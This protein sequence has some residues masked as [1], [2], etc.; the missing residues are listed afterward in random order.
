MQKLW[1]KNFEFHI[2]PAT[3]NNAQDMLQAGAVR[4]LREVEKH[5]WVALVADGEFS[6]EVET[7][8]SPHKIKAFTCECW[9]EGRRLMCAH[10][11]ATLYK[12]RQFLDQQAE[13]RLAKAEEKQLE[14]TG[15]L[16]TQTILEQASAPDLLEFVRMYARRDRDFALALKTWFAGS[17]SGAENPYILLI[18]SALPRR[19]GAHPL[20]EPEL[21]RLRKMLDDL[22]VQLGETAAQGNAQAVF[23]IATAILEKIMPLIPKT[24]ETK[25]DQLVHFCQKSLNHL[26]QLPVEQLS[27]ELRENRRHFLLGLVRKGALPAELERDVLHFLGQAATD[28]SLFQQIRDL[29]DHT[30]YPAPALILHLFLTALARRNMPEAVRRVLEDYTGHPAAIK[31][32]IVALH[33]LH[34]WPAVLTAG[35]YFTEK[36]LFNTSQRREIEDLMLLAAEKTADHP[37]QMKLLRA[38]YRE[39]GNPEMLQRLKTLAGAEWPAEQKRL[40][41]ELK[42]SGQTGRLAPL[43]AT[44]G[45]LGSLA[46]LIEEKNDLALLRQYEHLFFPAQASFVRDQYVTI[47]TAYLAEHFG[48]Q[49]SGFVREQLGGLLQKGQTEL[50]LGIIRTLSLRFPDRH[51]LP[52]ELAELFPKSKRLSILAK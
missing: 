17:L 33:Y 24:I 9:A 52:E 14:K 47:L 1:L 6:Y 11:A 41:A 38:R 32:A 5:F 40:V 2:N 4:N 31:D 19:A 23:R 22:E 29:F 10:I 12:I 16:S 46:R 7:I 36:K 50:V 21:K 48:R 49:A 26:L 35:E 25:R 42:E 34:A 43:F 27:P 44:D 30:P 15:R 28:D 51:S 37:R 18:D 45:D 3:W 39:N 13:A 8:I 20:R